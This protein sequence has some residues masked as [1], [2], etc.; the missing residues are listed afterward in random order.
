LDGGSAG[1]KATTYTEKKTQNKCTQISTFLVRFQPT[2]SVFERAKT[3]HAL[4]RVAT[5][6]GGV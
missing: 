3:V 6:I 5:V 1:S 2:I 4:E